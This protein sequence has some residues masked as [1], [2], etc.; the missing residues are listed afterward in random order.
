MDLRMLLLFRSRER[1]VEEF[2]AW[3]APP[4]AAGQ[5]PG[6]SVFVLLLE[7]AAGQSG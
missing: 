7:Y 1:S 2:S 3:L 6:D 5:L 4:D